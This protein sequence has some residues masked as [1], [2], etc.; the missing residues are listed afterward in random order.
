MEDLALAAR[1]RAGLALNPFT[2]N[3]EVDVEACGGAVVVKGSLFEQVEPVESV[4]KAI[5]GVTSLTV[6]DLAPAASA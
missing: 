5:S 3:L 6:E 2:S 1:V 4:V